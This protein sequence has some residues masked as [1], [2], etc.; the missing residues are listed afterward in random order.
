MAL[1][2]KIMSHRGSDDPSATTP[3]QILDALPPPKKKTK[4]SKTQPVP[5]V[6]IVH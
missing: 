2:N 6:Y 3:F 5:T 4:L 1:S